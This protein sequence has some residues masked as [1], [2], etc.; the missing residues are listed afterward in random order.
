M[1]V[2]TITLVLVTLAG[3]AMHS[4][5]PVDQ[6]FAE[7]AGE[8][9]PGASVMVI[10]NGKPILTKS[11]G[12]ANV[13]AGTRIKPDTNFRLASIT[14]QFTATAILMLVERGSLELD[15]SIRT[16]FPEFPEFADKI[17]I[18]HILQHT[19]GIQDYEPLYGDQFPNQVNDRGVVQIISTTDSANF[20]PGSAY[21]YSNSGYAILAVLV[22]KISGMSFPEFLQQNIF[23]PLGMSGT[24][25]FVDGVTTVADRAFGYRITDSGVA[26]A[27]QSA[28][29]AV[30]GDGGV[31]SSVTDLIKWDQAL[32]AGGLLSAELRDASLTPG[33]EDYGFGFRIDEYKSYKRIHHSGSTSGFRNHMQQFPDERLTIIILTNRAEPDVT[34][35]AEQIADLYLD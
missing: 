2:I 24:V 14:K 15:D 8:G 23:A 11:Y 16:H 22:E 1:R 27:D 9:M 29:S 21:S 28:W 3:C 25:A 32:Y 6:L 33:R 4:E 35:L 10:R 12:M 34:P 18:R 26:Y 30:L 5:K 7:Y 20:Q 31:Y 17:T 13:E 19:S